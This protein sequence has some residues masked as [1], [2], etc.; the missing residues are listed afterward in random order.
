[1]RSFEEPLVVLLG[2][3]DKELAWDAY[4]AEVI[5]RAR[6]IVLFGEARHMLQDVF[7]TRL[8]KEDI[9]ELH[10]VETFGQAFQTATDVVQPGE[11]VLLSPGCTSYDEFPNF[12]A[13]GERFKEM[14]SAL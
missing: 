4:A 6:A 13:R 7:Q 14:V 1:V 11:V 9:P 3:R 8:K 12:E 2:G 5:K 10:F